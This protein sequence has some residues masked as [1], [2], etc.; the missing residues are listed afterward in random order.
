MTINDF[1]IG[2][3]IEHNEWGDGEVIANNSDEIAI[4]FI[5]GIRLFF[6]CTDDLYHMSTLKIKQFKE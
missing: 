5:N 4:E 2:T 3:L 6:S 1:K